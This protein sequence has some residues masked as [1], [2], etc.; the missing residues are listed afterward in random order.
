MTTLLR[1][2][3]CL[4][5]LAA[6]SAN[7]FAQTPRSAAFREKYKL[8]Q[9][10]V[11]SRH[12]I[13]SPLSGSESNLGRITPHQWF[14]WTSAPSELSLRGGMLETAMGQFFRKWLAA[15]GMFAE[16]HQ[17]DADEVYFYANSMQR[18][19]A[20][21]RYFAAGMMPA[22]DLTIHHRY[23]P[24][25]MDPI[26]TPQLTHIDRR[27]AAQ[28]N[29]EATLLVGS[30][31]LTAATLQ[32][33]SCYRILTDVLD[34]KES[35]LHQAQPELRF[36]DEN[37]LMWEAGKEPAIKGSLKLATA[38]ADA[39]V[40]QYYESE[41]PAD[42]DFGHNIDRKAW[43]QI[44]KIK[45]VYTDLLFTTPTVAANVA[46][47]LLVYMLDELC[48]SQR[49]FTF[50]CGHDSNIAS[51]N[52][53]L[54]VDYYELPD[55][56]E[57]RTPIGCKLV[58]EKWRDRNGEEFVAVNL[59]YQSPEQLRNIELLNLNN[60]PMIFTLQLQEMQPNADGLYPFEEMKD[61]FDEAISAYFHQAAGR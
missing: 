20:T 24:S 15:E 60:P 16:N 29:L 4:L 43:E 3:W 8:K 23:A 53:A 37:Q 22:A 10:L 2:V 41:L 61:R 13:R 5:L 40:L 21:A 58:F 27:F 49:K 56:I 48:S 47:P 30:H 59:V 39:L 18:T 33:D 25:K 54:G 42:A 55:A 38:A 1:Y 6:T 36:D 11:L 57:K 52:A 45:D 35:P 7:C 34:W 17:P 14:E 46:H 26:F 32:L 31:Q 51:V 44:G 19:I 28:A 9:V 50:L 12:N